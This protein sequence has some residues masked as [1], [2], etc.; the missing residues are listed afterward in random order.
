[1]KIN[2]KKQ[3]KKFFEI[4]NEFLKTRSRMLSCLVTCNLLMSG[5]EASPALSAPLVA[6]IETLLE[7]HDCIS[8]NNVSR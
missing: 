2:L 3:N 1:M 6:D 7:C 5:L 8:I 4:K